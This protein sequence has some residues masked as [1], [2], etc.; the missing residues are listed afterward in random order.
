MKPER[1]TIQEQ[2]KIGALRIQCSEKE[3][4]STYGIMQ[5]H[6]IKG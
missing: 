5:Y 3:R 2:N 1:R 4:I 6:R